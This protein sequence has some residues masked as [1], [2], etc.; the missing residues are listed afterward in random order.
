MGLRGFQRGTPTLGALEREVMEL[1]WAEQA[2]DAQGVH[3]RL[4]ARRGITLSTVQSTLERLA[5]KGLLSRGKQGRAFHYQA[6]VSRE[7]LTGRLVA[8]LVGSL[9]GLAATSSGFVDLDSPVDEATLS[10][11]EAWIAAQR[12]EVADD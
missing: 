10:A 9:S 3:A 8:E 6:T 1:L 2:R 12:S 7:E 11:L 4:E 5:R